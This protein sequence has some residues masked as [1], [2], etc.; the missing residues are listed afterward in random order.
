MDQ[1]SGGVAVE[2][3][4][5][6]AEKKQ[7][8][9]AQKLRVI[10]PILGVVIGIAMLMYPVFAT[11]HNDVKHQEYVQE[12]SQ[13]I[14]KTDKAELERQ[15]EAADK[16]NED[17]TQGIILDP[18]LK[19]VAPDGPQYMSYLKQLNLS[20]DGTDTAMSN[21]RIPSQDVNLP[22]YHG[23]FDDTLK[24]GVGHLF[25]SSLPVGGIGSH[26]VLT[27]HTGLP[28]ATMF[29]NLSKVKEGDV[30]Y[31]NTFGRTMKYQVNDIKIV[32]PEETDSLKRVDGKD[33]VT[34]IT[35]TPYGINSHR[36][37]VTGERVPMDADD[38]KAAT[39]DIKPKAKWQWWM[40]LLLGAAI[41]S[42]LLM[43]YGIYRMVKHNQGAAAAKN[44]SEEEEEQQD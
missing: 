9:L 41:I 34:L 10:I 13:I 4:P 18:F 22:I 8:A 29:D 16:Y 30:F 11:R 44:S 40:F 27:G 3:K 12:Y 26:S 15:L 31:L 42:A 37:L 1:H 14:N 36:L 43:A 6:P 7:S 24:K 38:E 2:E 17:L 39:E 35:C 20:E 28:D 5:Q 21:V 25:G 32:L 33:L 23:T 19:E